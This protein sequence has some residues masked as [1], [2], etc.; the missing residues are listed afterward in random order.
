[1]RRGRSGGKGGHTKVQS[2]LIMALFTTRRL[3]KSVPRATQRLPSKVSTLYIDKCVFKAYFSFSLKLQRS[4]DI[5][6]HF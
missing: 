3:R 1:M 2:F 6:T 5:K 4:E